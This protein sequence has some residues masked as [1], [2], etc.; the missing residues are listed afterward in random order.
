MKTTKTI[1]LTSKQYQVIATIIDTLFIIYWIAIS[2]KVIN[3]P[4]SNFDNFLL[5]MLINLVFIFLTID[6]IKEEDLQK[7]QKPTILNIINSTFKLSLT[8]TLWYLLFTSQLMYPLYLM[9][10]YV[11]IV[12]YILT[13]RGDLLQI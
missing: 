3:E 13:R 6:N 2:F 12:V 11:V 7:N 4:Y 5:F 10:F 9:V 8:F 1:K